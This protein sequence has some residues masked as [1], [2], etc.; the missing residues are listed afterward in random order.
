MA[1]SSGSSGS[2]AKVSSTKVSCRKAFTQT[3]QKLVGDGNKDILMICTDSKGSVTATAFA[4]KYPDNFIEAGIAEQNAIGIAAGL[5]T[6]GKTVFVAGPAC[7]LS[8]RGYE[9][10]KVDV[11]YNQTNVKIVGV[12][13]G[14]SYGP[15]GG[16]H[17]TL[18][19]FAGMRALPNIEVFAPSDAVQTAFITEYLA[20][21]KGAAYMRTGRG[22]VE[23]VYSPGESFS[24]HKAKTVKNGDDLTI[25]AC[26]EMV[27]PA[28][29][30]AEILERQNISVRVLDMFCLK[31]ADTEAI[32]KAARETKAIITVEE[33]STNGGLGELV[34]GVVAQHK[35][36][37]VK[38]MGFP[39]EEYKVGS[40]AE[41]FDYYKLTPEGIAAEARKLVKI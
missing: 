4:Q 18:H 33:H 27:S 32:C 14:V 8:A 37:P 36:V 31:P 10:I 6:T 12:S 40:S 9:Q 19:D 39:D 22:D 28:T 41:L 16:T 1:D 34:C 38:I 29:K 3:L 25:I 7:F 20:K 26:G 23:A 35:P 2:F 15:L 5:A 24:I 13:A 21:H 11:A 30:A 17:T